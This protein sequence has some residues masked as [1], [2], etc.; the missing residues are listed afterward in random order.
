MALT[1]IKKVGFNNYTWEG[2]TMGALLAI[3]EA[4]KTHETILSRELV[5]WLESNWPLQ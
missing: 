4:L 2:L 1:E 5:K 3:K